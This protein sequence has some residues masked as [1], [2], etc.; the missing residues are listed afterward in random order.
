MR[1]IDEIITNS[2]YHDSRS[3][4]IVDCVGVSEDALEMLVKEVA[5]EFDKLRVSYADVED[6]LTLKFFLMPG[7][8]GVDYKFF[9]ELRFDR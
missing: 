3:V 7:L 4:D 1:L 6:A 9:K 5:E 2:S 8:F